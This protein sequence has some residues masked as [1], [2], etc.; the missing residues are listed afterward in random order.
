[1]LVHF[2]SME[3]RTDAAIRGELASFVAL[4]ADKPRT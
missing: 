3:R 2:R 4:L 1:V